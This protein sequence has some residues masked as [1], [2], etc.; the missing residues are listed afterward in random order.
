MPQISVRVDG[1]VKVAKGVKA[2]GEALPDL[3][4]EELEK[5]LDA[6]RDEARAGWPGGSHMGY[7]VAPLNYQR[8]GQLGLATTW[9]IVGKTYRVIS[10]AH[11]RA[12]RPYSRYVLGDAEGKGQVKIHKGRWPLMLTV[13][14]KW[15]STL[16]D[17]IN[18][19]IRRK[20][21]EEGLGL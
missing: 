1:Q 12:G 16:V 5:G 14:K 7:N 15:G 11:N 9:E 4:A 10:N 19:R 6:A 13:M 18:N 2:L 3:T 8:T 17:R 21:S 20:A